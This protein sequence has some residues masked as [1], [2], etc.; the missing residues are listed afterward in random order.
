MFHRWLTASDDD[1]LD[2]EDECV[3]C[4]VRVPDFGEGVIAD[5]SPIPLWCPAPQP[6]WPH[7]FQRTPIEHESGIPTTQCVWCGFLLT[8]ETEPDE[9]TW[10]CPAGPKTA[11]ELT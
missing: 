1:G 6:E 5:H 3:G 4:G 8:P 2:P 9:F 11:G 7:Y 10:E